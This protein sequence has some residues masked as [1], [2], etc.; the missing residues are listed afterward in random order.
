MPSAR[1]TLA[2]LATALNPGY[3][4][5]KSSTC[6]GWSDLQF[7]SRTRQAHVQR[8]PH[9]M[10]GCC[11]SRLHARINTHVAG[12]GQPRRRLDR[13]DA[14]SMLVCTHLQSQQLAR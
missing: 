11:T 7:P 10:Q 13:R 4:A 5:H 6:I 12:A 1:A 9:V 8:L 3:L 14:G 2:L